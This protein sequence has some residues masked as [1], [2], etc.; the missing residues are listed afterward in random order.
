[1]SIYKYGTDRS[2]SLPFAV[3][4]NVQMVAQEI[5]QKSSLLARFIS[6]GKLTIITAEYDIDSGWVKE[7]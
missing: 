1:L 7:V 3:K 4:T 2:K 6:E 5:K